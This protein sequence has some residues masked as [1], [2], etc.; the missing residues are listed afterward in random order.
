[1]KILVVDDDKFREEWFREVM[2]KH[3]VT[4]IIRGSEA[5]QCIN[6]TLMP[7]DEIWLDHDLGINAGSGMDVAEY[8]AEIALTPIK[9]YKIFC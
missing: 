7:F 6:E 2:R 5:I 8:L 3:D 4:V 1:M 9:K